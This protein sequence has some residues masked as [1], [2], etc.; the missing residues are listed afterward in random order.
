[1]AEKKRGSDVK[2]ERVGRL[3]RIVREKSRSG[4]VVG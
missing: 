3:G 1:V 2:G 4:S